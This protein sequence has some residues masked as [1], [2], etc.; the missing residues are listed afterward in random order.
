MYDPTNNTSIY[1]VISNDLIFKA[2]SLYFLFQ[3][4][5][6]NAVSDMGAIGSEQEV[7]FSSRQSKSQSEDFFN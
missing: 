6:A 7:F 5:Q 3:D 4:H 2:F 1:K